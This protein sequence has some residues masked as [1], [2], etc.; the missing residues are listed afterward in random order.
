[1]TVYFFSS[2]Y[3]VLNNWS[4]HAV[5]VWGKSFNTVEH[6]YHYAKFTTVRPDIARQI[7]AAPSPWAA[8]QLA[9]KY[10]DLPE[11]TWHNK[12]VAVMEELL[13]AK[14]SQNKD[15]ADRLSATGTRTIIENSPWDTFWG[16]GSDGTGLN[17]LGKLWVKLR[18][19]IK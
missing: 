10:N 4:A 17:T 8:M 13:R 6:A 16:C 19:K 9:K 3:D 15:V 12:K 1:M 11:H 14:L 5:T 2:P 7:M 18:D